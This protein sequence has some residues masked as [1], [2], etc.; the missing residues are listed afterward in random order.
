MKHESLDDLQ[1]STYFGPTTVSEC[2][3]SRK[4]SNKAGKPPSWPVKSLSLNTE[5]GPPDFERPFLNSKPLNENH[6]CNIGIIKSDNEQ[7]FH[8]PKEKVGTSPGFAKK[9]NGI[10]AKDVAMMASGPAGLDR[11][12]AAKRF[13]EKN[14]NSASFQGG[15]SSSSV[16][17][18]TEKAEQKKLKE[19]QSKYTDRERHVFKHSDEDSE[20]I[21]D[22][23]SDIFRFLDD[24]SVCDSLGIVQSSCYN[25]NGSL[26]QLTLKSEGDSSPE[27]NTVKLAKSKLD[28]LFHSLENTDDELKSSVCKL[29]MRIGEI[30]KKLESLSGVR[31]EI[32]QV[33]SKLNKLDEKIQEPETNGRQGE[34]T[35]ASGSGADPDKSHSHLH[36]HSD[37]TISPRVFQCHTTGHNVK[38]DNGHTGELCFSEGSNSDSLRMKAMKK[39]MFTRRSSRSL[40]EDSGGIE[41]KVASITNSPRDWRTVS[42]SCHPEDEGNDKDRDRDRDR[43]SKDRHRKAKEVHTLFVMRTERHSS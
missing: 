13:R 4:H 6:H 33:L 14:M 17:T 20:I 9:G 16:G 35:S 1:A 3:S 19:Y 32:S 24:M 38:T 2:V 30:E 10:K 7:H 18:Q 29:V 26:S 36:P 8:S 43:D 41:S 23:I 12:E 22:D 40:N 39:S 27:R 34:M 28:R 31:G 15:D 37:T 25:S 11:R 5:E 21:S 42:Y